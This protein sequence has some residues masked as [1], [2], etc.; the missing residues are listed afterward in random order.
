MMTRR[1]PMTLAELIIL[2]V[3]LVVGS[4]LAALYFV[5]RGHFGI[6]PA[7]GGLALG[8]VLFVIT[9]ALL[10]ARQRFWRWWR[11][12]AP[13]CP[14]GRCPALDAEASRSLTVEAN[15]EPLAELAFSC[16]C[17]RR[18][19]V[20][21]SQGRVF[22]HQLDDAGRGAPFASATPWGRW[23]RVGSLEEPTYRR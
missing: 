15:S 9:G 2:I 23:Q 22:A 5:P 18:Y 10:G 1:Q 11:P 14:C 16:A 6:L 21:S 13:R 20:R 4:A 19:V 12:E 7:L 8:S 17:G 3:H